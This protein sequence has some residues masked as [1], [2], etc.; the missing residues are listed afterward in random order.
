MPSEFIR[1]M[2]TGPVL[3]RRNCIGNRP[4]HSKYLL[5]VL[6]VLCGPL[7]FSGCAERDTGLKIRFLRSESYTFTSAE[8]RLI[9]DIAE[10]TLPE[11]RRLLPGTP[12]LIELTVR[13]GTNVTP[14]SGVG[15]DA[16]PPNGIMWTIDPSR[17]GGVT[18]LTNTWLRAL[19]FHEVHHLVRYT[20]E[21]PGSIIER[22]V[23]EGMATAFERDFAGSTPPWLPYPENVA[24]WATE[25]LA[26]PAG[27]PEKEW[28]F[29]NADGRRWIGYKV[30]TYWVDLAMKASGRSAA[31]LV[32]TP[33]REVLALAGQK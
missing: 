13:P 10:T 6:C 26:L 28:L 27:G 16:M 30:G 7:L 21:D 19:L 31:T 2:R 1:R 3:N 15:G 25:L 23:T 24:E 33:T 22:A 11:I 20:A 18:A 9:E 32:A 5:C 4:L 29:R 14:E 12:S 17:P 8:R